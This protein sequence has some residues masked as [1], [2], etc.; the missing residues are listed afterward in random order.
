MIFLIITLVLSPTRSVAYFGKKLFK[1]PTTIANALK[2][3]N[4]FWFVSA[5]IMASQAFLSRST[6]ASR[7]DLR[8]LV[9][10]LA[11]SRILEIWV[12]FRYDAKDRLSDKPPA[13][14][15]SMIERIDEL[16][17]AYVE[18]I[19]DFGLMYLCLPHSWFSKAP[20][21]VMDAVY[22][23]GTTITTIGLADVKPINPLSQ[24]LTLYEVL[25][26]LF[27]VVYVFSGYI[28]SLRQKN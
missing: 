8:W 2:A 1:Q 21:N 16:L 3:W 19:L 20:D 10:V 26:G 28:G 6:L 11:W 22:F 15:L 17:R 25:V 7:P 18:I 24:L 12:G 4:W 5:L 14:A 27:M 23:S 9:I 13:S